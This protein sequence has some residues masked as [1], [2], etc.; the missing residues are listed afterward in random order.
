MNGFTFSGVIATT[1]SARDYTVRVIP[2]HGAAVLPIEFQ[3]I[4]WE[5]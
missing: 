2:D 4:Q 5:H 3:S 1:R